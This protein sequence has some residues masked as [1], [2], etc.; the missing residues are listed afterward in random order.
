[1][2]F[3][4][5]G[6]DRGWKYRNDCIYLGSPLILATLTLVSIFVS[7]YLWPQTSRVTWPYSSG[8]VRRLPST[9][10]FRA[11]QFQVLE[12]PRRFFFYPPVR[13]CS[14]M[15]YKNISEV[16]SFLHNQEPIIRSFNLP[17]LPSESTLSFFFLVFFSFSWSCANVSVVSREIKE[18]PTYLSSKN[19]K[20]PDRIDSRVQ[21]VWMLRVMGFCYNQ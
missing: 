8:H 18:H 12:L 21:P 7:E 19:K 15:A 11:R 14:R 5:D 3:K 4:C 2:Q 9:F 1:M 6:Y 13:K 10:Y 16:K 17:Y 20:I